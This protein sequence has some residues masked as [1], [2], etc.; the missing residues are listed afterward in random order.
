MAGVERPGLTERPG[1]GWS[2]RLRQRS[3]LVHHTVANDSPALALV[4]RGTK[5]LV[6]PSRGLEV[7]AGDVALF[8]AGTVIDINNVPDEGGLYDAISVAFE[9]DALPA[10][11]TGTRALT[12]PHALRRVEPA[13]IDAVV[14]ARGAIVDPDGVPEPIARHRVAELALW[15]E[16]AGFHLRTLSRPT[17]SMMTRSLIGRDPARPWTSAEIARNLAMSEPTMRRRLAAEGTTLTKVMTDVRLSRALT[18]LQTTDEPISQIALQAGYGDQSAFAR[19]FRE[20][21]GHPPGAIRSATVELSV[22]A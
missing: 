14:A 6:A 13:L 1:V 12:E 9:M 19:G 10:P 20:R 8:P 11:P 16:R 15:V 5:R 4:L 18:L 17:V 2:C 21:F 22:S 3:D 7:R